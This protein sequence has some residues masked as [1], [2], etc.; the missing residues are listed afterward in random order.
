[1]SQIKVTSEELLATSQALSTGADNVDQE[2]TSLRAKVDALIGAQWS[3]AASAS[4][5]ELYQEWQRG[6]AQVQEALQGISQM[7]DGT[8]RTYQDT[9]DALAQQLRG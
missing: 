4:F 2:L 3:G 1:M 6:A 5:N 9:E 7:L 8:A